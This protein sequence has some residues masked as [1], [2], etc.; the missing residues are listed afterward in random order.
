M[1]RGPRHLPM[2]SPCHLYA[3]SHPV[4]GSYRPQACAGAGAAAAARVLVGFVVSLSAASLIYHCL[5]ACL[6]HLI[7]SFCCTLFPRVDT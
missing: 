6:L 5:L 2:L 4:M 7:A 3:P 1:A